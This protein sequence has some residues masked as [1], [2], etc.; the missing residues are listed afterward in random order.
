MV[1]PSFVVGYMTKKYIVGVFPQQWWSFGGDPERPSTSQLNLQPIAA[2]FFEHGWS[3]GY[4]GNILA[5]WKETP[6]NVWTVPLGIA[7][8]KVVKLGRLPVKFGVAG[9]YMV[10]RPEP[11]GQEWN[12]QIQLAPVLPRLVK[13]TLF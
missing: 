3:V 5:N 13:G 12:I 4:S 6:G 9:Q 11:A 1:G 10:V 8:N 7:I 2:L